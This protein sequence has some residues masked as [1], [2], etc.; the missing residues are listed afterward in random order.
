MGFR[1]GIGR[2]IQKLCSHRFDRFTHTGN[3]VAGEVVDDDCVTWRESRDQLLLDIDTECVAGHRTFHHLGRDQTVAAQ[4]AGEG[5]SLPMTP[6]GLAD[7]PFA[8]STSPVD[9]DHLGVDASLI[10]E[11]KLGGIKAR[12]PCLP[13]FASLGYVGPILLG[14]VQRFF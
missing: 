14:G 13:A 5:C 10:D 2:Q 7:E 12:L 11:H 8:P 9:A 6:W 3:F 4:A 1:W